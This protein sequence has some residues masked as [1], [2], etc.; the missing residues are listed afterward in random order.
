[1]V[2]HNVVVQNGNGRLLRVHSN[3]PFEFSISPSRKDVANA[4]PLSYLVKGN[5]DIVF[6]GYEEV[7]FQDMIIVRREGQQAFTMVVKRVPTVGTEHST[8]SSL[9]P[10]PTLRPS[11]VFASIQCCPESALLHSPGVN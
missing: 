2:Y 8:A 9:D 7:V 10:S 11:R 3:V 6:E 5:W 1:M 4:F